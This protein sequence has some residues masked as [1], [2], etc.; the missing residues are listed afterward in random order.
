MVLTD[1]HTHLYSEAFDEDRSEMMLRAKEIGIQRFFL[2]AIDSSYTEAMLQMKIGD[3][4]IHV[5]FRIIELRI[6]ELRI[7]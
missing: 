4:T 3:S 7:A 5:N 6:N 1:T 2:P